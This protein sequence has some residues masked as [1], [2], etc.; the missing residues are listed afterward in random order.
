MEAASTAAGYLGLMYWRGEGLKQ[1]NATARQWFEKG[2]EWNNPVSM[3]AMGM[4]YRDSGDVEKAR[5]LFVQAAGKD[6]ADAQV[7]LG[8]MYFE[9][10]DYSNAIKYFTFSI[11]SGNLNGMYRLAE[12]YA[13]GL[14]TSKS[15]HT[16]IGVNPN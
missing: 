11:R 16:A 6:N 14:G 13:F 7:N 9:K 15:C 10:K 1:D 12:M 3:N 4:I 8:E 2:I 5:K